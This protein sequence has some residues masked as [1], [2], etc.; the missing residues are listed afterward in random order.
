MANPKAVAN[1]NA[2]ANPKDARFRLFHNEIFIFD[3]QN[4]FQVMVRV[5]VIQMMFC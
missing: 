5:M 1:P 3:I 4:S 2:V